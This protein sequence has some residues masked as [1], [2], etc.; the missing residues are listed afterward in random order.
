M[1]LSPESA[2]E[3]LKRAHDACRLAHAHLLTGPPGS[4]KWNL[5]CALAAHVLGCDPR[6]AAAHPDLHLVQPESKSRRIIVEQIRRLE[7]DLYR[8]PLL[9]AAKAA[10]LTDADRLQPAAA[11]AFLK[12]LEEPPEGCLLILTSSLPEAMLETILSRC[13]ETSLQAPQQAAP[14]PEADSLIATFEQ[15]LLGTEKPAVADAFRLA[16]AFLEILTGI[17][18]SIAREHATMLKEEAAR[19]KNIPDAS[20]WLEEREEQLKA[21]AEA[22]ALREPA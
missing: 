13:M 10:I 9:A 11:N 17:R 3:K 7:S 19:Y 5:A 22:A 12:T 20:A 18:E 14:P 4:G 2:L 15:C 6:K 1:P 8:K 16:Q 21:L